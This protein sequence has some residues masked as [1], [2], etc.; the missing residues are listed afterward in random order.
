MSVSNGSNDFF[1]ERQ[2]A[3]E[4]MRETAN[5]SRYT[6][7]QRSAT[8]PP[9]QK[10]PRENPPQGRGDSLD[11]IITGLNIPFLNRIKTDSDTALILGL[12][13]LLTAEKTDRLLLLALIYILL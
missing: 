2:R 12:V 3:V 8:P 5:R 10:P 4:R 13:L 11:S 7:P 1:L 6:P 9:A